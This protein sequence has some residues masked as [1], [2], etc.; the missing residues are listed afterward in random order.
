MKRVTFPRHCPKILLPKR[1][2]RVSNKVT[3]NEEIEKKVAEIVRADEP[4]ETLSA[5]I[6]IFY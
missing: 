2:L 6:P 4:F 5:L 1:F 3:P